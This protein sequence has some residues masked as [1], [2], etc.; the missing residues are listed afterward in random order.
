ME[1]E[2]TITL[3]L[4]ELAVLSSFLKDKQKE[5]TELT[6]EGAKHEALTRIQR[7]TKQI[8]HKVK[9]ALQSIETELTAS[10]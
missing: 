4:T 5:L 8:Q 3:T 7:T 1:K 2:R 9:D 10:N 6:E